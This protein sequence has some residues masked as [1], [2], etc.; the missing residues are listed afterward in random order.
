MPPPA[1]LPVG[2]AFTRDVELLFHTMLAID[3]PVCGAA[4]SAETQ[5]VEGTVSPALPGAPICEHQ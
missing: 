5:G 2:R 1:T 4:N 3:A